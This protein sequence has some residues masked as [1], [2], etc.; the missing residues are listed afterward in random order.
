MTADEKDLVAELIARY[1]QGEVLD[2]KEMALLDE[3]CSLSEENQLVPKL[4]REQPWLDKD[5]QDPDSVPSDLLWE[6]LKKHIAKSKDGKKG[7]VRRRLVKWL[8]A[9]VVIGTVAVNGLIHSSRPEFRLRVQPLP[10]QAQSLKPNADQTVL[11]RFDGSLVVVDTVTN[12]TLI[13]LSDSTF[14]RKISRDSLQLTGQLAGQ[15][16]LRQSLTVGRNMNFLNLFF[17]DDSRIALE[18]GATYQW[19]S[20]RDP[21]NPDDL[22]GRASFAIAKN[23]NAPWTVRLP[24][25]TMIH[26]LGTCFRIDARIIRAPKVF[27]VSGAVKVRGNSGSAVLRPREQAILQNGRPVV[28]KMAVDTALWIWSKEQVNIHFQDASLEHVVH[29]IARY[30]GLTVSNPHHVKGIRVT[31]DLPASK[32]LE[33]ISKRITRIECSAAWL[34]ISTD[35]IYITDRKP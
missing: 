21:A 32:G 10:I 12:G 9:A 14:V 30:Y 17:P 1:A 24:D 22:K 26:E 31:A 6:D 3:W 27:M 34:K 33:Y 18:Y 4:L 7:I 16:G 35:S 25:G 19:S 23:R 11:T 2:E 5:L 8:V 15:P 29:T 13:R 20:F 28:S